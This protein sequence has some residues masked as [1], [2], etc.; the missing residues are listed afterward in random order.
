M[1]QTLNRK[2]FYIQCNKQL[3][4]SLAYLYHPTN[5]YFS[6]FTYTAFISKT[7]APAALIPS[8]LDRILDRTGI[9]HI[10]TFQTVPQTSQ[11][12]SCSY[13]LIIFLN[14]AFFLCLIYGIEYWFLLLIVVQVLHFYIS[15][16]LTWLLLFA[17]I[18]K[19]LLYIYIYIYICIL[20]ICIIYIYI[21]SN[22]I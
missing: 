22:Y 16:N 10:I 17:W 5:P 4:F 14:S 18:L 11:L 20:Y 9:S 12:I 2:C 21:Y 6:M 8:Q 19:I 13:P 7:L 1:T 15:L 3:I